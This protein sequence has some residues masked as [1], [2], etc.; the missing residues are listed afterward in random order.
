MGGEEIF[1]IVDDC[2]DV[3]G[4]RLVAEAEQG[5]RGG[6][7]STAAFLLNDGELCKGFGGF[8]FE[9]TQAKVGTRAGGIGSRT[10]TSPCSNGIDS[11]TSRSCGSRMGRPLLRLS[12][13]CKD[14]IKGSLIDDQGLGRSLGL[15]NLSLSGRIVGIRILHGE[16]EGGKG[17]RKRGYL[18]N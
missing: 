4:I 12:D 10:T 17:K 1:E 7:E 14:R 2:N 6:F 13:G 9:S 18:V 15:L 5:A 11:T 8:H 16:S 3:L